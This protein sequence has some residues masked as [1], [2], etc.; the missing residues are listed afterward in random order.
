MNEERPNLTRR[1]VQKGFVH[2]ICTDISYPARVFVNKINLAFTI[3]HTQN[4][5]FL[6]RV[7]NIHS[8]LSIITQF[9]SIVQE[10]STFIFLI[11]FFSI[12]V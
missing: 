4:Y 5:D 1:V 3:K 2:I 6:L 7:N 10:N 8:S 11:I 12:Q 9:S